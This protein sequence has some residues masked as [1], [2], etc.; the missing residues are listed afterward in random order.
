MWA[1]PDLGLELFRT[2]VSEAW[3]LGQTIRSAQS[4]RTQIMRVIK[5]DIDSLKLF[6]ERQE[7]HFQPM[8]F[9]ICDKVMTSDVFHHRFGRVWR[10]FLVAGINHTLMCAHVNCKWLTAKAVALRTY[11]RR[12]S[13]FIDRLPNGCRPWWRSTEWVPLGSVHWAEFYWLNT[14]LE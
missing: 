3:N 12:I 4:R 13:R 9:S 5:I 10:W 14:L 11:N 2:C 7:T 6:E 1:R 8:Q